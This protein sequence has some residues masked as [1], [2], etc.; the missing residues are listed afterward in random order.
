MDDRDAIAAVQL[1]R[2]EELER[3]IEAGRESFVSVGDALAE[4]RDDKLYTASGYRSFG[5]YCQ[6]RWGWS[7]ARAYRLAEQDKI[8]RELGEDVGQVAASVLKKLP[9]E[10]RAEAWQAAKAVNPSREP[11]QAVVQQVVKELEQR[12]KPVSVQPDDDD[13][14]P[15]E[16]PE[17]DGVIRD[18]IGG[19]VPAELAAVFTGGLPAFDDLLSDL[20]RCQKKLASLTGQDCG[21]YLRSQQL[22]QL[23]KDL[24]AG[25]KW[26][27]PYCVAPAGVSEKT[28]KIGFMTEEQYRTLQKQA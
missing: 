28:R 22:L 11:T 18:Q 9:P 15:P 23:L 26:A 27:R 5:G 10:A 6:A 17:S 20:R 8:S 16:E 19:A 12:T 7:Q 2:I 25:V 1:S 4:I 13:S 24:I 14:L 21:T 3:I